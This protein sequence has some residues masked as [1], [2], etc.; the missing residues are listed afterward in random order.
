MIKL[1]ND[2]KTIINDTETVNYN[3]TIKTSKN[4]NNDK[5]VNDNRCKTTI[6]QENNIN[7]KTTANLTLFLKNYGILK[8]TRICYERHNWPFQI[9]RNNKTV[10]NLKHIKD[11]DET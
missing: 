2:N 5:T 10:N 7:G 9:V 3:K 6:T 8:M 1:E 11:E 4:E